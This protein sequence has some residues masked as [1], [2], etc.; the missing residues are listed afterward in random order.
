MN[1]LDEMSTP[2]LQDWWERYVC[3]ACMSTT[4]E[5]R[6][7]CRN[8]WHSVRAVTYECA[9]SAVSPLSIPVAEL[10]RAGLLGTPLLPKY[11]R[12]WHSTVTPP[13]RSVITG[14]V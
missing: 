12:M 5:A 2:M 10:Q 14:Y 1:G 8:A 9:G 3:P 11:G 4:R 7:L 6:G 13:R